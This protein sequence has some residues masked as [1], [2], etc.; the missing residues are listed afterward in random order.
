[1]PQVIGI[2]VGVLLSGGTS[3][4][5]GILLFRKLGVPC[6]RTESLSL[7]FVAGSACFSEVLFLVCALGLARTGVFVAMGIVAG[8]CA[9]R[10]RGAPA[11]RPSFSPLPR[12]WKWFF[13]V[14][15]AAFG[16]V[17]VVNAMVPEM[18]PDGSAYHL[19]LVEH[20]LRA[21]GFERITWNLY[22]SLSQGIELLFL[23][24]VALG[25]HSAAAM[26][27]FLFLLDLPLLMICY[28]APPRISDSA[29]AAAFLVFASPVVGLDAQPRLM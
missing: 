7:A 13:G 29:M 15:F 6:E 12:L 16:V 3:L 27:Q 8:L 4:C 19:P 18:S 17:Y 2:L 28:W 21:H 26:V 24:A 5:L 14:L 1:M 23:P 9:F 25:G 11:D 20:Y 22:G 10:L